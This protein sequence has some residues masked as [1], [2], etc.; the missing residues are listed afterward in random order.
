MIAKQDILDRVAEWR[1]RPDVIEKDY[2]LGWVLA[3]IAAHPEAGAHWVFKGGTCLKKCYFE[4][5]RFSEDLDFTLTPEAAYDPAALRQVLAEV[6]VTAHELS[7]VEFPADLVEVRERHDKLGRTTF[8]GKIGYRGPLQS[9]SRPR[10]LFDLTCHEP[11][12]LS[13]EPRP[14]FHPYPDALPTGA[15]VAAYRF[16]ELFAEKVR[17]L[18]ERTRPRDLYDVVFILENHANGTDLAT[19][20]DAYERKCTAKGLSPARADEVVALAQQAGELRSEWENMLGHQLPQLPPLDGVLGRLKLLLSWL[21]PAAPPPPAPLPAVASEAGS[22]LVAP[23]GVA[24]WGGGSPIETIR[25]AGASR[26]L[27]EFGY[28]GRVRLAEPYSLRRAQTGNLL[29]YAWEHDATNIKAFSVAEIRSVRVTGTAFTP[30]YRVDLTAAG[31]LSVPSA[32]P[33]TP[34]WSGVRRR[35]PAG[36]HGQ[37]YVFQCP[38]CLKEFR[39]AKNDPTLRRHATTFG[40]TCTGRRGYLLRTE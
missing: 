11:L 5:Y 35:R 24:Y 10:I 31:S 15:R 19:T 40:T 23:A 20:R 12:Q 6:V 1:L 22:V 38:S 17:A 25:F 2:V 8:Q 7:G 16:E 26:L 29:L 3:A 39:H 21:D 18:V 34:S 27:V 30:R 13:P 14:V 9:P 28:H 33:R 32:A 37:T 4:T 36:T